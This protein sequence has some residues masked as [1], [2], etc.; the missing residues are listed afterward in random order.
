MKA[1]AFQNKLLAIVL[2]IVLVALSIPTAVF[3]VGAAGEAPTVD[4]TTDI[5]KYVNFYQSTDVFKEYDTTGSLKTNAG[6][7]T[8]YGDTYTAGGTY[9]A[10]VKMN[11]DEYFEWLFVKNT[12][13]GKWERGA[14]NSGIVWGQTGLKI[15]TYTHVNTNNNAETTLPV[16]VAYRRGQKG[17]YIMDSNGNSIIPTG[18]SLPAGGQFDEVVL[19]VEYNSA[20]K[21]I[22]IW[23]KGDDNNVVASNEIDLSGVKDFEFTGFDLRCGNGGSH[24]ADMNDITNTETVKNYVTF[25]DFH[26]WGDVTTTKHYM[27]PSIGAN[28]NIADTLTLSDATL[29]ADWKADGQFDW[30]YTNVKFNGLDF[31]DTTKLKK[32]YTSVTLTNIAKGAGGSDIYGLSFATDGT[33]NAISYLRPQWNQQGIAGIGSVSTMSSDGWGVAGSD[34]SLAK[35]DGNNEQVFIFEYDLALRT[36][37]IW[38]RTSVYQSYW[39]AIYQ[40]DY[41]DIYVGKF[42]VSSNM[43]LGLAVGSSAN[44]T[45]FNKNVKVSDV[46]VWVEEADPSDTPDTP[47]IT[48]SDFTLSDSALD[49]EYKENGS[50]V[51]DSADG[52]V[53]L[54]DVNVV[55]GIGQKIV[56]SFDMQYSVKA[57]D[58]VTAGGK[59]NPIMVYAAKSDG[60]IAGYGPNPSWNQTGNVGGT[61]LADSKFGSTGSYNQ[62]TTAKQTYKVVYDVDAGTAELWADTERISGYHANG[63]MLMAKATINN[64]YAIKLGI[65]ANEVTGGTVTVSNI[66]LGYDNG[67][68]NTTN[69][70]GNFNAY[71]GGFLDTGVKYDDTSVGVSNTPV[72]E[73]GTTLNNTGIFTSLKQGGYDGKKTVVWKG[74]LEGDLSKG[75]I[76]YQADFTIYNKTTGWNGTNWGL[77]VATVDGHYIH[78]GFGVHGPA[79]ATYKNGTFV[80]GS[81]VGEQSGANTAFLGS[82]WGGSYTVAGTE[83]GVTVHVTAVLTATSLTTYINGVKG[84]TFDFTG[85]TVVP[86]FGIAWGS[87]NEND[88]ISN[89][90]FMGDGFKEV[91]CEEHNYSYDCDKT[92]NFC[93]AEREIDEA[94][95]HN[96]EYS[97]DTECNNCGASRVIDPLFDHDYKSGCATNC[98]NCGLPTRTEAPLDHGYDFA[99]SVACNKCGETRDI[100]ETKHTF[101][102]ECDTTCDVCGFVRTVDSSVEHVYDDN[103]DAACNFC[104]VERIPPH[105]YSSDCDAKCNECGATRTP[106]A[107]HT[108]IGTDNVCS[109]CAE[110]TKVTIYTLYKS[111]NLETEFKK[112]LQNSTTLLSNTLVLNPTQFATAAISLGGAEFDITKG[113]TISADFTVKTNSSMES[114]FGI[115]AATINNEP[116]TFGMLSNGDWGN[117]TPTQ[118]YV[119]YV[120]KNNGNELISS[121]GSS[122][123]ANDDGVTVNIK[124]IVTDKTITY[125][126]NNVLAKTFDVSDKTVTPY[127]AFTARGANVTVSNIQF[128]GA[129]A[130]EHVHTWQ[131]ECDEYCEDCY[132]TRQT[133]GHVYDNDTCDTNCNICGIVREVPHVYGSACDIDCNLCGVGRVPAAD[134]TF[135]NESDTECNACGAV[136]LAYSLLNR[137]GNLISIFKDQ[138]V[139][140]IMI[141]G[142]SFNMNPAQFATEATS[143]GGTIF[144]VNMGYTI[145]ADFKVKTNSSMES[146]FGITAVALDG[147]IYTFGMLS[148][149]NWNTPEGNIPTQVYTP[150]VRRDNVNSLIPATGDSVTATAEG[151]TVSLKVVVAKDVVTFYV[152]NVKA[153][154]LFTKDAQEVTP[155]AAFTAR[156]ANVTVS[157]IS[158]IVPSNELHAQ[159]T[160]DFE[161][162]SICND[163]YAVRTGVTHAYDNTCDASCNICSEIREVNHVYTSDCDESCNLCGAMRNTTVQHTFDNGS[164][165]NCNVCG[166]TRVV[167]NIL[168]KKGN[169]DILFADQLNNS[170]PVTGTS[171]TMTP[172]QMSSEAISLGGAIIDIKG[173]YTISADFTVKTNSSMESH[174]GITAATINNEPYTFGMLSNGDWNVG[175]I[176]GNNSPTQKYV[177][178][179]RKN[180]GNE[181]ISS[182]GGS[183]VANDDGVK[184]NI[185]VIV[186]DTTIT[187]YIDNVLAKTLDVSGKTVAPY[188]AFTARGANVTVDNIQFIG[189]GITKCTEHQY[190][191]ECDAICNVCYGGFREAK[192]HVYSDETCDVDC[193]VCGTKR[194]VPH[195]RTH[196]C[197]TKCSKCGSNVTQKVPHTFTDD[198][199]DTCNVCEELRTPPHVYDDDC[200]TECNA[201]KNIR[202]VNKHIY[203]DETDLDCETCGHVRPAYPIISGM[204][205]HTADYHINQNDYRNQLN[206]EGKFTIIG[207][208][209][210]TGGGL[211]AKST[212]NIVITADM[213]FN[214]NVDFSWTD[215]NKDGEYQYETTY[216]KTGIKIGT[217]YD[218]DLKTTLNVYISFRRGSAAAYIFNDGNK[219]LGEF[220]YAS[221]ATTKTIE[222]VSMTILYEID[223]KEVSLW[224]NNLYINT[225]TLAE[226]EEFTFNPGFI[227]QGVGTTAVDE[228]DVKNGKSTTNSVTFSNFKVL[229]DLEKDPNFVP[230]NVIVS[231]PAGSLVEPNP[232]EFQDFTNEFHLDDGKLDK[233]LIENGNFIVTGNNTSVSA[234]GLLFK[235]NGI[236]YISTTMKFNG[237]VDFNWTEIKVKDEATGEMVGTGKYEYTNGWG[238]YGIKIGTYTRVELDADGNVKSETPN[239]PVYVSYRRCTSSA[240]LFDAGNTVLGS[241]GSYGSTTCEEIKMT[242]GYDA[243]KMAVYLWL[244]EYFLK[245][246]PVSQLKDF[247]TSLGFVIQ[248]TGTTAVDPTDPNNPACVENSVTFSDVKVFGHFEKDPNFYVPELEPMTDN[249]AKYI[250]LRNGNNSAAYFE[251]RFRGT[252]GTNYNFIGLKYDPSNA[253][254]NVSF[255]YVITER[256]KDKDGK[257]VSWGSI[258]FGV[259]DA[260]G[261]SYQL[262]TL[263]TSTSLLANG[264]GYAGYVAPAF[265]RGSKVGE[266]HNIAIQYNYVRNHMSVWFDGELVLR[267]VELPQTDNPDRK[268]LFSVLFEACSGEISDLKIWGT[269]M[270]VEVSEEYMALMNDPFYTS[271][272]IPAK[273]EGNINYWSFISG[274]NQTGNLAFDVVNDEF[275]NY[276]SDEQGRIRFRD[277][278]G[279]RNLNG[280]TND[281]TFVARFKYKVTE[282]DPDYVSANKQRG[283]VFTVRGYN[284]P[285]SQGKKNNYE[286]GF[287]NNAITISRLRDDAVVST[288]SNP[289]KREVG[290]E[291]D[292]SIVSAPNWVKIFVDGKLITAVG[293]LYQYTFDFCYESVHV[294]AEFWDMQLYDVKP[295]DASEPIKNNAPTSQL[296]GTTVNTIE[297]T[298]VPLATGTISI[299]MILTLLGAVLCLAGAA[300]MTVVYIK[301]KKQNQ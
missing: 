24:P 107:D 267:A 195:V 134:H 261:F 301:K 42:S 255:D 1:K 162:D 22:T 163:C 243:E 300:V 11:F 138:L 8:T 47:N 277:S 136:K 52:T 28:T 101:A 80:D 64:G 282:E 60:A 176:Q 182:E 83:A 209:A 150:F 73:V 297:H 219:V 266:K 167:P 275:A 237:N 193:N 33:N 81:N 236:G 295:N 111:G 186:T 50:I 118:S 54:K 146:H 17:I 127:A 23:L 41:Q 279:K 93:G 21:H 260:S 96:W 137:K 187:Y 189:N 102:R 63:M 250:E 299:W 271:T 12:E 273:P 170:S 26:L 124:V 177:P 181:L 34:G 106:L 69:R 262:S 18:M 158:V 108:F 68:A 192:P 287:Y 258:R 292:I 184:V 10:S 37:D 132:A 99:C 191:G 125:Y 213:K 281:T 199:D 248:G 156:G 221:K 39:G 196:D 214:G 35:W 140:S 66:E 87:G 119:P 169:L 264:S 245:A 246:V 148:N 216:G 270:S 230:Q 14:G 217:Y 36:V 79:G 229:G 160:Y 58:A 95:A 86:M 227:T 46:Q 2:T 284:L 55:Y 30:N 226:L 224:L 113:Y 45:T 49:A 233:S 253:I 77:I 251:R 180:N 249:L 110:V 122:F 268:M 238:K 256:S 130:V 285:T 5:G 197:V 51:M 283:S 15:G 215:K 147:T 120:R 206:S 165:M 263:P 109:G 242:V 135:D 194:E 152:N 149:G 145:S 70:V 74:N 114:H 105:V 254:Y 144:D 175:G 43:V 98:K 161:C 288:T 72:W 76:I 25:S 116:H 211:L 185:K 61:T 269:G 201:C 203:L 7:F 159:H 257:D 244:D 188:A 131:Y 56:F 155:Y 164:D 265:S 173:G 88:T 239:Q 247:K 32:I 171:F 235:P 129:G 92:C 65:S 228:T 94:T 280:I 117:R 207:D 85:R 241:F 231:P 139:D 154:E 208:F 172:K 13:T 67:T 112:Q 128:Y 78:T 103:C 272:I 29:D 278:Y 179:T 200:D 143:L 75:S 16:T 121:E 218:V 210:T 97:C 202:Y 223:K 59:I 178:Y 9:Y 123:V 198:C 290:K 286:I 91:A 38:R 100:P 82:D 31:A 4:A 40:A 3:M 276:W 296:T 274:V 291:Y 44:T 293:G 104:G 62:G 142:T 71:E 168:N 6:E 27:A 157:N 126:I 204:E 289:W 183:I 89:V 133:T 205:D 174:F 232:E 259:M 48:P 222:E 20:N 220:R 84:Q 225:C 234:A 153:Y 53:F 115:T 90:K 190:K 294:A 19:T 212:G 252:P 151:E 57:L 166:T 298:K 240:Y 141:N